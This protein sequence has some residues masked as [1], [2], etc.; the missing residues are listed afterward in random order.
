LELLNGNPVLGGLLNTIRSSRLMREDLAPE[1]LVVMKG[2]SADQSTR[3]VTMLHPQIVTEPLQHTFTKL[4]DQ[5]QPW[6]L[7]DVPD[8]D[9]T[10]KQQQPSTPPKPT[11][12]KL[13]CLTIVY[14][15]TSKTLS[16]LG[17]A[18]TYDELSCK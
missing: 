11:S 13:F 17:P 2:L 4:V 9:V 5:E 1:V 14:K 3:K 8:V 7:Q 10:Y 12:D 18:S 6:Q 15:H 16:S